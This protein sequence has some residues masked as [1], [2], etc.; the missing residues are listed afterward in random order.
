MR[1]FKLIG[2]LLYLFIN[3][4]L[5]YCIIWLKLRV[6]RQTRMIK[7]TFHKYDIPWLNTYDLKSILDSLNIIGNFSRKFI[8]KPV[9]L[10]DTLLDFQML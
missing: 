6:R 2:P 5:D 3:S 8:I 7:C 1:K 10:N 9:S 4:Y